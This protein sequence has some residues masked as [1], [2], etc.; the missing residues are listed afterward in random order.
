MFIRAGMYAQKS[1]RLKESGI[2]RE[3]IIMHVDIVDSTS[4]VISDLVSAHEKLQQLYSRIRSVSE[5]FGGTTR[6]L[7]G[8]A[9]VIEFNNTSDAVS[10]AQLIQSTNIIANNT[11]ID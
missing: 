8:D 4:L 1:L 3:T 2:P 6:E 9:A 10:A 11:R 5:K 7:R